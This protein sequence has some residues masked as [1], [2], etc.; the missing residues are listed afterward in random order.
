MVSE[1]LPRSAN[2][3]EEIVEKEREIVESAS[4]VNKDSEDEVKENVITLVDVFKVVDKTQ[5]PFLWDV[6]LRVLSYTP[7]SVS[8]EESFAI[9]K[10]RMHQNMKTETAFAFVEMAKRKK[11]IEFK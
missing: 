5:F 3:C 1:K 2:D 7:T 6:V 11:V 4:D 10:R 9:L 8:C